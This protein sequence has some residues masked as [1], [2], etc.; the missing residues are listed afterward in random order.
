MHHSRRNATLIALS[1]VAFVS[2][3]LPDGV[4]SVAWPS[5]RGTFDVPISRLGTLLP[6]GVAA[7]IVSS[8]LSGPFERRFGVGWLLLA[9]TFL[10]TAGLFVFAVSPAWWWL[11]FA[12]LLGGLGAGGIDAGLNAFAAARFG[13]KIVSWLHAS[14]GVGVTAGPLLMTSILVAGLS[15]RWGYAVIAGVLG[16]LVLLFWVTRRLWRV[17]EQTQESPAPERATMYA[18]LRL[19][20]AWMHLGVFWIYCGLEAGA[21]QLAYSV[22][23]EQRGVPE[24]AAGVVI[25]GY[26]AA[27][28]VGRIAFGPLASRW[29]A[30]TL[31]R[32]GTFVAPIG[33]ALFWWNVA[34]WVSF[35][36]LIVLGL[37]LAPIFPMMMS[38]T[39]DRLGAQHGPNAVGLQVSAAGVGFA[40]LPGLTA[41]L[42]HRGGL[43]MLGPC[44]LTMAIVLLLLQEI[45]AR[46]H[47]RT[48]TFPAYHR[49]SG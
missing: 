28:T 27:I 26:W 10:G 43:E 2:L 19:P 48:R 45:A 11:I 15:W 4:L 37:G 41:M 9:S 14:W 29:S 49:R 6:F 16:S 31:L 44:L 30:E 13:P 36:G 42:M 17:A 3:G 25:G 8:G 46:S 12:M 21:G 5:I 39:A 40:T 23:T 38:I 7:Y 34:D 47:A 18:T 32:L 35:V 20:L 33:V 1:F 24:G 22:L